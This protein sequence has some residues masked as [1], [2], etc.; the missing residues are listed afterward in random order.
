MR[1][2]RLAERQHAIDNSTNLALFDKFHRLEQF[3]FRTHK[4]TEYVQVSI[5]DLP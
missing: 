4:R 2:S 5:E 1:L 3:S